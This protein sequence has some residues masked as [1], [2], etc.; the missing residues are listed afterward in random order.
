MNTSVH[1]YT[2]IY[3]YMCICMYVCRHL[4][5]VPATFMC[6]LSL[7]NYWF[8][9]WVCR[10]ALMVFISQHSIPCHWSIPCPTCMHCEAYHVGRP[11]PSIHWVIER[12]ISHEQC[13][14]VSDCVQLVQLWHMSSYMYIH[15]YVHV[16]MYVYVHLR[17]LSIVG[18]WANSAA[19][20]CML[21]ALYCKGD[22]GYVVYVT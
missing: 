2:C 9:H 10:S 15:M 17:L 13:E 4:H 3:T 1:A 16:Y 5:Y 14:L 21:V 7:V 8:M 11:L 18:K 12:I 22:K 20:S 6:M 19:C